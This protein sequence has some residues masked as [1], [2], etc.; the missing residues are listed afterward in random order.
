MNKT[1]KLVTISML[2]ALAY[3]AVLVGRIPLVLFLKY[4]PKDIMI[5]IGGF[6][7]GPV[8][9]FFMSM[10][11]SILEM[12]TISTTGPI[13]CVMNVISTCS[14][15]CTAS[16]MYQKRRT[17]SGAVIGLC[18][19]CVSMTAVML[20]WNYWMAPVYMGYP[21]EE[22]AK[23]LLQAFLPFNLIKSGLNAAVT[24]LLYKS[25]VCSLRH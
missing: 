6:I 13:G 19:G 14:F 7:F 16:F 22:V 21:R 23:L 10:I 12:C 11:V 18:L 1:K 17:L 9:A 3:T 15:A 4:D 25:V 20:L 8:T 24:M 5:T 2:C